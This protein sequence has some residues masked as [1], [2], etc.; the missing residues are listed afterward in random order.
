MTLT[1]QFKSETERILKEWQHLVGYHF[2]SG[3]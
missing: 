1:E 2:T 3:I